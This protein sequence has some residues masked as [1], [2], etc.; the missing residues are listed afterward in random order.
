MRRRITFHLV[1]GL[2]T[3]ATNWGERQVNL[4]PEQGIELVKILCESG[5]VKLAHKRID[6]HLSADPPALAAPSKNAVV[7]SI[8]PRKPAQKGVAGLA[9]AS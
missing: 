9:V 3:V 5:L 2:C 7:S 8:T 4:S 1:D 6:V